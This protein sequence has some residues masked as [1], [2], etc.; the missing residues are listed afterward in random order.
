MPYSP[1]G[2]A[3]LAAIAAAQRGPAKRSSALAVIVFGIGAGLRPGELVTLRGGDVA[4]HGR[5]VTVHIA[6]PAAR[7][8]PVTSRYAGR[9]GGLARRAGSG[10]VFRPGPAERGDKNFVTNFARNLARDPAAPELSMRRAGPASSATTW[11]PAPH[12]ASC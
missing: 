4:R 3:E 8:I 7:A 6:G 1:A 10:F 12:W 5:R 11:Q 2:R 9:A